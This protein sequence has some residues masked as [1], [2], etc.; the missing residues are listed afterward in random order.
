VIEGDKAGVG[1]K[2]SP[3]TE[4]KLDMAE[5]LKLKSKIASISKQIT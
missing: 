4:K 3:G 1:L 5:Q 2:V